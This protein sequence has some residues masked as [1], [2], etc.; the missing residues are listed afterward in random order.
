MAFFQRAQEQMPLEIKGDT[1]C[2][3]AGGKGAFFLNLNCAEKL[4]A[5][6]PHVCGETAF[7]GKQRAPLQRAAA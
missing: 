7:T 6:Y 3:F 5:K 1:F 4:F 2:T